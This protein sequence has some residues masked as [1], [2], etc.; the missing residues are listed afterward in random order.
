M[1]N[2]KEIGIL[3]SW[4]V[5]PEGTHNSQRSGTFQGANK[6]GVPLYKVGLLRPVVHLLGIQEIAAGMGIGG[7]LELDW[8]AHDLPG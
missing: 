7:S 5:N 2:F 8:R 3:G 1:L 6:A 4:L